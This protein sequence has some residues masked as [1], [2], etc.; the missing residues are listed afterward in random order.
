MPEEKEDHKADGEQDFEEGGF[1]VVDRPADQ[2]RAVIDRDDLDSLGEARLDLLDFGLDAVDDIQGVLS[3]SH[4]HDGGDD[5][6]LPIELG[7][8]APDV[9]PDD[10]LPDIPDPDGRSAGAGRDDDVLEILDRLG[11]A[12]AT[13]HVFGP[14]ELDQAAADFGIPPPHRF[15]DLADSDSIGLETVRVKVDLILLSE[16]S[17]CRHLGHPGD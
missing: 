5:V 9:G 2:V 8:S 4:D 16:P 13:N 15:G 11:V 6:S 12:A 7:H 14:A 17:Y 3:L 10:D 1:Q